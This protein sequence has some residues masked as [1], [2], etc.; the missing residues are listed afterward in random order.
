MEENIR[1]IRSDR[2]SWKNNPSNIMESIKSIWISKEKKKLTQHISIF[3]TYRKK[4]KAYLVELRK[5][6]ELNEFFCQ[7]SL[8]E[9]FTNFVCCW[10]PNRISFE[11]CNY[12][13]IGNEK[14]FIFFLI[15]KYYQK[16]NLL[17]YLSNIKCWVILFE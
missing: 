15:W 4:K 17:L 2:I 16:C 5:L 9:N 13:V 10:I 12:I 1:K 8:V 7:K 6:L 11:I 14:N 3:W